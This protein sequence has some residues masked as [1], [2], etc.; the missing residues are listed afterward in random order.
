VYQPEAG[1]VT[2]TVGEGW[3][4]A[5]STSVLVMEARCACTVADVSR[6]LGVP[7]VPGATEQPASVK[8]N[9]SVRRRII[10]RS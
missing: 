5:G 7:E 6:P 9:N 4:V 3:T 2:F 8:A 1:A 10:A